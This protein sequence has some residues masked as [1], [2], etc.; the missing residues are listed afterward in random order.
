MCG[1]AGLLVPGGHES[2][3]SAKCAHMVNAIAHRGPDGR[4]VIALP[5][6]ALGHA[7]LSIIDLTAAAAQPMYSAA[8]RSLIVFNGEIYN[9][10]DLRKELESFGI[11]FRTDSDTEV[12]LAAYEMWGVSFVERLNGIF[13]FVLYDK[14][15]RKVIL[16][17]DRLGVK[18]LYWR[19]MSG[20]ILFGSEIKAVAAGG[21]ESLTIDSLGMLE[22]LSF[23][24]YLSQR[25][26]FE[27]IELFPAGSI[28][29]VD[30]QSL[31]IRINKF[32]EASVHSQELSESQT[33]EQLDKVLRSAVNRQMEADVPVNSFLSGGIDSCAI[34]A[35]AARKVGRI[36]T[37]T[38]GF[39]VENVTEIERQFDER[40]AAEIVAA[41][42]GSEHY[43]TVLNAD[44][45]I[46]RMHDWAWHA[47]EPRVGSSFPNFCISGLASRFTKVCM[48]GT[49]GDEMFAGYPWRYQSALENPDWD[50]FV[51]QYYG[52]WHR[53]MTPDEFKQLSAPLQ[54]ESFDG[55]AVFRERME[56]ARSRVTKSSNPFIDT[57]L[58]FEAETF[59]QGLLIVEDKASMAHGLEVR[60]PLLD[61]ELV[62]LALSTPIGYKLGAISKVAVGAYGSK[63]VNTMTAFSNGKRILRDVASVYVP[64]EVANARKQ[65]FSPPVETWFRT[66]LRDWLSNEVFGTQSP[67]FGYIDRKIV[68]KIWSEH[69]KG[70]KNHRLFIWGMVSLFLSITTFKERAYK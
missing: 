29:V 5:G 36:K 54:P 24:N 56:S 51:Q 52:F 38:C 46:A 53:M 41:S 70:E 58:I 12:L 42:L 27:G 61:N 40:R 26:L 37:F 69:L 68:Q 60:V 49:G 8:D 62:D 10:K 65:G 19:R 44:D 6:V 25:T 63:G 17:R 2:G 59:L 34:A 18:P 43:E 39:G 1:I 55:Y 57:A 31:S 23:Q 3:L 16:A 21:E 22:F 9:H 48:S 13:A 20:S 33:R 67:L 7:R 14:L 64:K 35:L 47:E 32:W 30:L 15:S 66:G 11:R 50:S 45:F 28:A 4:G